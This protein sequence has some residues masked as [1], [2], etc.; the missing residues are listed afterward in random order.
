[1]ND[2]SGAQNTGAGTYNDIR[3]NG[4]AVDQNAVR[5]RFMNMGGLDL[6]WLAMN[7]MPLLEMIA[8]GNANHGAL[9]GT[10]AFAWT[11]PCVDP[12]ARC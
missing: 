2:T 4:R 5:T 7:P 11:L 12:C 9:T 1:M 3:F 6:T 8:P 10:V